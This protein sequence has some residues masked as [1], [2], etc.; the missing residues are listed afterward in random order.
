MGYRFVIGNAQIYY[1]AD[2]RE[3]D[4]DVAEVLLD[5]APVLEPGGKVNKF[6]PSYGYWNNAFLHRVGDEELRDL[7][8][9]EFSVQSSVV[10][11]KSEDHNVIRL[12]LTKWKKAHPNKR[13]GFLDVPLEWWNDHDDNDAQKLMDEQG[14]DDA[15]AVLEWLDFWFGW[16][17]KNCMYPAIEVG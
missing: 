12:A 8:T 11:I 6:S 2:S 5:E 16:A 9:R 3:C 10:P 14:I 17:L 1:N 4:A 13:G 15:L 7:F